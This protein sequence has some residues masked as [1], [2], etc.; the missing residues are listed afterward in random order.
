MNATYD[1][2]RLMISYCSSTFCGDDVTWVSISGVKSVRYHLL[3]NFWWMT[4]ADRILA[5]FA[6][7][8]S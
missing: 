7:V 6:D 2:F 8:F 1:G 5:N 3:S 4:F